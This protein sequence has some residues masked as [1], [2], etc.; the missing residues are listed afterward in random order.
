[1]N[2]KEF[3]NLLL[4][5]IKEMSLICSSLSEVDEIPLSLLRLSKGK[6]DSMS[7][8]LESLM[9][10]SIPTDSVGENKAK[11]VTERRV[12]ANEASSLK[13]DSLED[14]RPKFGETND[15]RKN[16]NESKGGKT[17]ITRISNVQKNIAEKNIKSEVPCS[18]EKNASKGNVQKGANVPYG[19]PLSADG[20]FVKSLKLCL[21]DKFRYKKDLFD[22]DMELLNRTMSELDALTSLDDAFAYVERFHWDEANPSVEDFFNLLQRRF[23]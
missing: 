21:G 22:D 12:D 7:D 13:D 9:A 1:M 14:V 8:I 4:K 11:N 20:R 16:V 10:N 23:S 19:N 2:N 15:F 5:E 18:F 3:V 17:D 6:V